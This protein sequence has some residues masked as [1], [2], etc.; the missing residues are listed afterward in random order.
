MLSTMRAP[1]KDS[2]ESNHGNAMAAMGE[3]PAPR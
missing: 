1:A 2:I 3:F